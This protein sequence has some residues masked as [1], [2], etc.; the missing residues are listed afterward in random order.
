[1]LA[2]DNLS[3][4]VR[5]YQRGDQTKEGCKGDG[6]QDD[7]ARGER[8][9]ARDIAW[10]HKRRNSMLGNCLTRFTKAQHLLCGGAWREPRRLH[11]H[12]QCPIHRGQILFAQRNA[13]L[14]HA[15]QFGDVEVKITLPLGEFLYFLAAHDVLQK[16]WCHFPV[17]LPP[18]LTGFTHRHANTPPQACDDVREE[19]KK[20]QSV[21][22]AHRTCRSELVQLLHEPP[23]AQ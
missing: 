5:R 7:G 13:F 9:K 14:V 10:A 11:H 19:K 18:R 17:K 12:R 6:A 20:E 8:L 3:F 22:N 2:V 4:V 16:N 23:N 15:N 1:M 21:D